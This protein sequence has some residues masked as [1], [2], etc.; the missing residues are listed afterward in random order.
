MLP[1]TDLVTVTYES[2][3]VP[4][5]APALA[6]ECE[7]RLSTC[8]DGKWRVVVDDFGVAVVAAAV[9][10]VVLVVPVVG[11]ACTTVLPFCVCFSWYLVCVGF[12]MAAV[13]FWLGEFCE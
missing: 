8:L 5:A 3:F 6:G 7:F 2:G 4:S 10:G 12:T 13:C 1:V 9:A 11:D